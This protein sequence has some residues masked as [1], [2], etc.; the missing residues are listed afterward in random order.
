VIPHSFGF[1]SDI[2]LDRLNQLADD[3]ETEA[4]AAS[5]QKQADE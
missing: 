3:L 1:R 2:D 5:L 4:F